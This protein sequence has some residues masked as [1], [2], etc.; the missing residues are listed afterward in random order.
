M[1]TFLADCLFLEQM[2]SGLIFRFHLRISSVLK[3]VR[4]ISEILF[5]LLE[6]I[7]KHDILFEFILVVM[8]KRMFNYIGEC[9]S[10]LTVH[11][12]NSPEEIL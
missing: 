4:L 8:E 5:I 9:H 11:H 1:L 12:E 2:S 10:F 3:F 6:L 7:V